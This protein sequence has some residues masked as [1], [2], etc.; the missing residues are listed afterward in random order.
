MNKLIS[1][2]N[3]SLKNMNDLPD[4]VLTL[5]GM[6]GN[7]YQKFINTLLSNMPKARF[8]EIGCWKGSTSIAALYN[9]L[10]Y[11]DN[12]WLI[13]NW[14]LFGGPQNEFVSNFRTILKK[15]PNIFNV[16]CFSI[17]PKSLSLN[18]VNVYFYDGGHTENDHKLALEYY[19][20][21]LDDEFIYIVD[22]WNWGFVRSGTQMAISSLELEILYKKEF[23]DTKSEPGV[24]DKSGWWNGCAIFVFRKKSK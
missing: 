3:K 20:D 9:N 17:D 4:I 5:D 10:D 1:A 8:L 24:F 21:Y 2:I 15:E 19:N 16:D 12:Y 18:K 6:C 11:L 22:D 13:D 14:S 7:T 23:I